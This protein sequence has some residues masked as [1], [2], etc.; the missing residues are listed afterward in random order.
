MNH[1]TKE[2]ASN[3]SSTQ[4]PNNKPATIQHKQSTT[5]Q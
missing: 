3:K 4:A 1:P 5:N 2:A